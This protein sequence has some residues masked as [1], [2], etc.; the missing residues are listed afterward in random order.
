MANSPHDYLRRLAELDASI[1]GAQLPADALLE[2][3]AGLIAGRVGCRVSEAHTQISRI[4]QA[5]GCSAQEIAGDVL[6]TLESGLPLD[7]RVVR[8]AIEEVLPDRPLVQQQPA[9][10]GR[11]EVE[12]S[13]DNGWVRTTQQVLAAV[14][15][16]HTAVTPVCDPDG[17]IRDFG[18]VAVS[19][20][21]VDPSGRRGDELI[22]C[23]VSEADPGL[24]GGPIWLAWQETLADRTPRRVGP[25]P[26]ERTFGEATIAVPVVVQIHPVGPGLVNTWT[27]PDDQSRLSDRIAQTERLS[28]LGW[29]EWD[30]LSG[31]V[32]W[33]DEMYRIYEREPADGPLSGQQSRALWLAEDEPIHQQGA[34][35]FGRGDTVD[36]TYRAR[37][38]GRTKHLRCVVDAVRDTTGRPIKVFGVIQDVTAQEINRADLARIELQLHEHRLSLRARDELAAQLQHIILPIPD[39][40]IELPG[41]HAA[42]RYLP[43]EQASRVGGDWYHAAALGDG[44]VLIAIGDAAGH[45][46]QAATTMA[47]LRHALAALSI[48]TTTDPAKLL[49]FLNRLLRAGDHN[50]ATAT[51]VIARYHPID[52]TL[53]WAQ[54]GHPPPLLSHE[55]SITALNRPRGPLLGA[56]P[57]PVYDTATVRLNQSDVLLLYTDGLVEH[58]E[59]PLADGFA[60]A[61]QTLRDAGED[62]SLTDLVGRFRRAN[63]EDDTCI[64]AVRPA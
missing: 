20:S 44:H 13:A 37:I 47:R 63:A 50:I 34:I 42:V 12:M 51:A 24:V 5:Q 61:I 60:A 29:G 16:N 46:I 45:G 38:G 23:L 26:Y 49:S 6:S 58:R 7:A 32:V 2:R 57:E 53:V 14:G 17:R 31:E 56:L 1:A 43:A 55:G 4:A 27:R 28:R 22:G 21:V 18:I 52:R 15:G 8:A 25:L 19:Q 62:P 41:L 40:I 64:M 54:A 39:G 59:Q 48:T 36:M 35:A 33:S 30:L 10:P 11:A 9:E 3:A